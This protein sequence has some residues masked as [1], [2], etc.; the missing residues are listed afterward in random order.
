MDEE[1]IYLFNL[2]KNDIYR[3]AYSYTGNYSDADDV[4]QAVFIKLYRRIDKFDSDINV[5]KW[6]VKVTINECKTL[7]LS[8]WKRKIVPFKEKEEN[9][10]LKENDNSIL[11]AI[12]ELPKKYRLVIFLYY[13]ENFKIKEI[14]NILKKNENTVK[15]NLARARGLL[16]DI[17]KEEIL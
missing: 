1:F 2:F 13:Y 9:I 4:T 6:L 15:T 11:L 10:T 17:L 3:L 5:K 12:M 8:S 14:A 16:K 7:F